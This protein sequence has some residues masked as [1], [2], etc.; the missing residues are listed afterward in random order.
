MDNFEQVRRLREEYESALDDAETRRSAYHKAIRKLYLSGVPLREIASQLGM[1][2][3]RVHQIVGDEPSSRKRLR[4]SIVGGAAILILASSG[5]FV[6]ISTAVTGQ[7]ASSTFSAV[8]Q[9]V[10]N[11]LR[12]YNSP[13]EAVLA[14]AQAAYPSVDALRAKVIWRFPGGGVYDTRVKVLGKGFC[15]VYGSQGTRDGAQ[16]THDDHR[17]G[18]TSYGTGIYSVVCSG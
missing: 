1:S 13:E 6:G 2:H 18:W 10:P 9:P 8:A 16:G 12:M 3:Q 7:E 5:I 14:A 17:I 4:R 15:R 11:N